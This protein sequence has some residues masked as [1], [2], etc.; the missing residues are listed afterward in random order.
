MRQSIS[1]YFLFLVLI[2]IAVAPSAVKPKEGIDE[3]LQ[4]YFVSFGEFGEYYLGDKFQMPEINAS[5]DPRYDAQ[6]F[7]TA[8]DGV[9]GWCDWNH[10]PHQM[11]INKQFWDAA[12]PT[13]R[14]MVIFHELGH[15]VLYRKHLNDARPDGSPVSLMRYTIYSP[16]TYNNNRDYY[17]RELFTKER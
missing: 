7:E 9:I 8:E 10:R 16:T 1:I 6:R 14:E 13:E 15:C 2:I 3:E 12:T 4:S 5:I 17:L 11:I